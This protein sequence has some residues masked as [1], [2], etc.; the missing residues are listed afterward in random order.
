MRERHFL[1]VNFW[2][3]KWTATVLLGCRIR[4]VASFSPVRQI[5]TI[6]LT[7]QYCSVLRL[8]P[9]SSARSCRN[10]IENNPRFLYENTSDR[11]LKTEWFR[12]FRGH[13]LLRYRGRITDPRPSITTNRSVSPT[14]KMIIIVR[15]KPLS[16][17]KITLH[18]LEHFKNC[19]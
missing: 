5:C 11:S 17:K 19:V 18:K 6:H 1:G 4:D 2:D 13:L 12:F 7:F 9:P 10:L 3:D 15:L 14:E 8:C 16:K